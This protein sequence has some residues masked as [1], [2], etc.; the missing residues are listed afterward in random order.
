MK[1]TISVILFLLLLPTFVFASTA[2][3]VKGKVTDL[4]TGEPLIGANVIVVGTS[5]GAATDVNGEYVISNVEVGVYEVKASYI[6]YQAI[7]FSNV[8]VNADLTTELNFKL[9]A[10]GVSVGE[11][12]VVAKRPLINKSNTNAIRVTTSEDI[13][14]LPVR[15]V[16]NL[17]ALTP[18]VILQDKIGRASCR[19]RV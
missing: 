9:P 17:L 10:E 1:R 3:R 16:A 18:G 8:R 4:Q 2:G 7:T 14:L 13:D 12:E 15:G 11:V 19:E 6:G 5:L